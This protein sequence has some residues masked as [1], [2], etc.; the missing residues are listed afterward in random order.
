M[1][2]RK[3]ICFDQLRKYLESEEQAR[4]LCLLFNGLAGGL[5]ISQE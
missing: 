1:V 3:K 2:R 5:V 4:K